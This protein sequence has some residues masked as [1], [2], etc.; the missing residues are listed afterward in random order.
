M[1]DLM[2][3]PV[4]RRNVKAFWNARNSIPELNFTLEEINLWKL[5]SR[6]LNANYPFL[7]KCPFYFSKEKK[8]EKY[9][10]TCKNMES[11]NS[12]SIH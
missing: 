1:N 9:E 7:R 12:H 5:T 2:I 10:N 4:P 6:Q 8:A 3:I 11:P